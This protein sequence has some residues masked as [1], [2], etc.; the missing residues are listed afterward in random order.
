MLA[1]CEMAMLKK[2]A[3][4]LFE[5]IS[6]G[7]CACGMS[8]WLLGYF[9]GSWVI[10]MYQ[11]WRKHIPAGYSWSIWACPLPGSRQRELLETSWGIL[12]FFLWLST[13]FLIIKH[14]LKM[15]SLLV[16]S[17]F[18]LVKLCLLQLSPACN[19]G[20]R[21]ILCVLLGTLHKY[22]FS[23]WFCLWYRQIKGYNLS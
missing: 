1:H 6:S 18:L 13:A 14:S 21:L 20:A 12:W 8:E 17:V 10:W 2:W 3:G 7:V 15:C 5:S 22:S 4:L 19:Y 9:G 11:H 23:Q 16:L